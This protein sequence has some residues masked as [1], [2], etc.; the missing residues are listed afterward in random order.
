MVDYEPFFSD[1]KEWQIPRLADKRTAGPVSCLYKLNKKIKKKNRP[2]RLIT[3]SGKG[4]KQQ[5]HAK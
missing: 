2:G 5:M 1:W 4:T 3:L